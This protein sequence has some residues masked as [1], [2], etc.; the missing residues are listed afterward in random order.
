MVESVPVEVGIE[1][2]LMKNVA[3]LKLEYFRHMVLCVLHCVSKKVK[4][5]KLSVTLSNLN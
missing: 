3:K 1:R 4:T 2:Q 5:I